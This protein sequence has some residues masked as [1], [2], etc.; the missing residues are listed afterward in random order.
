MPEAIRGTSRRRFL[1]KTTLLVATTQA[2]NLILS[3][4][5][6]EP[7]PT[8]DAKGSPV[9]ALGMHVNNWRALGGN[10][11]TAAEAARRCGLSHIELS[12]LHGQNYVQALG[13][14]PSIS[15]QSNP[16][17][18]K[19]Y[20]DKL[21]LKVSQLDASFPM[22]GSEGSAFGVPY[23][24]QAI[25][26]AAEIGCGM[27]DTADGESRIEGLTDEEVFRTTC[28]NYR[29]CLSWAEDYGVTVN[30]EPHGPYTTNGDFLDR[31]FSQL[32]SE[33]LRMNF[34][35]GNTFLAGLDPLQYL[36]RFRK[37]VV[38]CHIKDVPAARGAETSM[39]IGN[40]PI[41]GG[42]NAENIKKCIAYLRET[43]WTGVMSIECYGSPENLR[44]SIDFLNPLVG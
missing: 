5:K 19:R 37:Q 29:Q 39:A 40:V 13:Y 11:R 3:T 1:Q 18:L 22:M 6:A 28:Q 33:R 41:G 38:H 8:R 17:A 7:R 44:K 21:G 26:F 32:K 4:A 42:A 43:S 12:A 20:L 23:V 9:I 16:R 15:L 36:K 14:E 24:Q 2:P 27:V 25:R 34:D 31:L 35:M 30:I 10:Y